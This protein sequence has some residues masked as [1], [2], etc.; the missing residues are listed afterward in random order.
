MDKIK[1]LTTELDIVAI[2]HSTVL[3]IS[4]KNADYLA[5]EELFSDKMELG[6]IELLTENNDILA[7]Y[8]GYTILDS[9]TK[10]HNVLNEATGEVFHIIEVIL[11]KQD[12]FQ[13]KLDEIETE[14]LKIKNIEDDILNI[15]ETKLDNSALD[16]ISIEVNKIQPLEQEIV[17]L[18][19]AVDELLILTLEV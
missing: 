10:K 4:F 12:E 8:V 11:S 5:I 3:S 15:S 7:T 17:E 1:T 18:N 2:S 14:V 6:T 13:I 19:N 9:I 16:S